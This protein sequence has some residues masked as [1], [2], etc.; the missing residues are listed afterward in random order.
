MSGYFIVNPWSREPT[1]NNI[2]YKSFDEA[3]AV[4]RQLLKISFFKSVEIYHMSDWD[5][6]RISKLTTLKKQP[7]ND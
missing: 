6:T 1:K 7:K 4:A 5:H 2:F 3:Y